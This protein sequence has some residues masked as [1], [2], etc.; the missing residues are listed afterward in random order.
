MCGV[1]ALFRAAPSFIGAAFLLGC[2]VAAPRHAPNPPEGFVALFNGRDLNGWRSQLPRPFNRPEARAAL[3][4]G[5]L[6]EIQAD[7]DE[8]MREHW[9][10]EDGVLIFDG[11]NGINLCTE[12]AYGDFELLVEWRIAPGGDSG[13]YLRGTP[14]VQ[15]W[16]PAQ[17]P[18][19]SGGL[20]NR[21]G[22]CAPLVCADRP[23]GEW[24]TFRISMAGGRVTTHLNGQLVLKNAVLTNHW[25]EDDDRPL[26]ASGPIE[27]QAHHT[28]LRF[29][30]IYVKEK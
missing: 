24:N 30:N 11:A 9:R 14:Q 17:W 16:D 28:P 19:G 4:P 8:L 27:L 13:I 5:E 10:V 3:T 20:Y 26:T 21:H 15:I 1:W 7:A 29:R 2:V 18:E 22:S 23:T 12:R 25:S 6:A